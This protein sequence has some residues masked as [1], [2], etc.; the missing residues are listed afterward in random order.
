MDGT[1]NML[2]LFMPVLHKLLLQFRSGLLSV[3]G[4]IDFPHS[5]KIE[6][7]TEKYEAKDDG[8]ECFAVCVGKGLH[9]RGCLVYFGRLGELPSGIHFFFVAVMVLRVIFV[10]YFLAQNHF[11]PGHSDWCLIRRLRFLFNILV[12]KGAPVG[13]EQ[14]M[15]VVVG[16]GN[17][18]K[19]TCRN[20]LS[21]ED[22]G[23]SLD[24]LT[25]VVGELHFIL[26]EMD[27]V[28]KD[29]EHRTC[30]HDVGVKASLLEV[31]I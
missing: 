31:S 21:C 1:D 18:F 29:T 6:S 5:I 20:K 4:I 2:H 28:T 10:G 11:L 15:W 27:A 13:D 14:S 24:A 17:T 3:L 23:A 26:I 7:E 25:T 22:G 19:L 30:T 8:K 16:T 12:Q 9:T